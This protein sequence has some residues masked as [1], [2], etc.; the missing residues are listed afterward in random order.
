[1]KYKAVEMRSGAVIYLTSFINIG[2]AI[3]KLIRGYTGTQTA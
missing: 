2:S 3:Q 1:M